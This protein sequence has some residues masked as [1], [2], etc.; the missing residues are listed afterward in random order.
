M[1]EFGFQGGSATFEA[2]GG[3]NKLAVVMAMAMLQQDAGGLAVT[4]IKA[5][6]VSAQNVGTQQQGAAIGIQ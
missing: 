2:V 5:G 1:D 4:S 3:S 6:D